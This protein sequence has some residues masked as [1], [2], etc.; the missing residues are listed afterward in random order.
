MVKQWAERIK[1]A[2]MFK[3][4]WQAIEKLADYHRSKTGKAI[5]LCS[6]REIKQLVKL[7]G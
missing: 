2:G 7:Y 3:P 6:A 5:C 1:K 4:D